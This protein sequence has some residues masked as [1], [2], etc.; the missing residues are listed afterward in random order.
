VLESCLVAGSV[1][2]SAVLLDSVLVVV[3]VVEWDVQWVV[4]LGKSSG[5]LLVG[6]WVVS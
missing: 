6:E 2:E 4:L 1:V 3:W 5:D